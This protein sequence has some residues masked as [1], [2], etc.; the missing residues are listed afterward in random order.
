MSATFGGRGDDSLFNSGGTISG[1]RGNDN[2]MMGFSTGT[3]RYER[4][5]GN[6][7]VDLN[8]QG[9][10]SSGG[11]RRID[12]GQGIASGDLS[13]SFQGGDLIIRV[14]G[15]DAGSLQIKSYS[16]WL[17][18]ALTFGQPVLDFGFADGSVM[19]ELNLLQSRLVLLSSGPNGQ[20][21]GSPLA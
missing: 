8:Y 12:F 21:D 14:A 4:G 7:V 13:L 2:L 1:G 5:D 17:A 15:T 11:T 9:A 18:D 3:F 10:Y 20:V 6:D 19:S 16:A